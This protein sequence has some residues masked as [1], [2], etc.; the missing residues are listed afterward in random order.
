MDENQKNNK[1]TYQV[2]DMYS[3]EK[4]KNEKSKHSF[5]KNV[6][7]PFCSGALGACLVIGTCFGIPQIRNSIFNNTII[8]SSN[9]QTSRKF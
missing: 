3:K 8:T 1:T 5:S 7:L 9:S 2:I 6:F 4:N